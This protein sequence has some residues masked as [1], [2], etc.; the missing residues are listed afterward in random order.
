MPKPEESSH[1]SPDTSNPLDAVG[2]LHANAPGQLLQ[3]ILL[4]I[5]N[6]NRSNTTLT[7]L[8]NLRSDR[9]PSVE[10]SSVE[11]IP[12]KRLRHP[13]QLVYRSALPHLLSGRDVG[14][15]QAI[16]AAL[17][18][19]MLAVQTAVASSREASGLW[20]DAVC[21]LTG[22]ITLQGDLEFILQDRAIAYWFRAL[23]QKTLTI[24]AIAPPDLPNLLPRVFVMQHAHARCCSLLQ[25]AAPFLGRAAVSRSA[26]QQLRELEPDSTW[27]QSW[28]PQQ[29]LPLHPVERR[30]VN[31]LLQVLDLVAMSP[32]PLA[33]HLFLQA[34]EIAAAFNTVHRSCQ[35]FQTPILESSD[36]F[37][38]LL[39]VFAAT[40][41]VLCQ[42]LM[43][44]N[45]IA[46]VEL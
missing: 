18:S 30:L 8:L 14:S 6:F 16:A 17:Q 37:H 15:R 32:T 26:S 28:S 40:R 21:G 36:R 4:R 5:I 7:Q 25:Q 38:A 34:E 31:Q 2:Q 11:A 41:S 1:L 23:L 20:Q 44:L 13:D 45:F 35:L 24:P 39:V 10:L 42:V 33:K 46:P 3:I 29:V 27:L 43:A 9:L 12:L 19:Q 22:R